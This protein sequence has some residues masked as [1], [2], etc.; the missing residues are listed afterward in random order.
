MYSYHSMQAVAS[1][2][3]LALQHK[4]ALIAFE[5]PAVQNNPVLHLVY[6]LTIESIENEINIRIG[7][8]AGLAGGMQTPKL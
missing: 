2:E 7:Q 8:S 1:L 6:S 5:S 4:D 3:S